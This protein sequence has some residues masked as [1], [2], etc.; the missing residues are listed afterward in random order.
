MS[1]KR[2]RNKN[3]K[4][5]PPHKPRRSKAL[6]MALVLVFCCVVVAA[7]VHGPGERSRVLSWFSAPPPPPP[8]AL[9]KEYVYAGGKLVATEEPGAPLSPPANVT[10]DTFSATQIDIT[11]N[12]STGADH[13][14]VERANNLNGTFT[15]LNSN[16]TTTSYSDT[17]VSSINAYIYRVRAANS[18]GGVSQYGNIDIATAIAF[19]DAPLVAGSTL[20]KAAHITELRQAVDAMRLATNLPAVTWTDSNLAGAQIK[21]I[22]VEELRTNL[23]AALTAVGITPSAY[24]NTSLSGVEI[25]KVHIDELRQRVR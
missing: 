3:Y 2:K 18:S 6:V 13:Y 20:I 1:T 7:V 25:K 24:T 21:A 22:H 14:Q 10:A 9:S 23:D 17:T 16:V 15:M 4:A 8:P 11:W 5:S 12:P 19:T